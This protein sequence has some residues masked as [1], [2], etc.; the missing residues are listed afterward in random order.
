LNPFD[1]FAV[2]HVTDKED[3]SENSAY[4]S[5]GSSW[6]ELSNA[7]LCSI[8]TSLDISPVLTNS[9]PIT[10]TV[11]YPEFDDSF[12][13]FPNPSEGNI[14]VICKRDQTESIRIRV[15]NM[16]GKLVSDKSYSDVEKTFTVDLYSLHNGLFI[17]H[18]I[19]EYSVETKK[20]LIIK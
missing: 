20:V 19:S 16:N 9:E 14:N 18:F 2:N 3:P 8:S 15:F 17:V 11:S 7:S 5:D 10:D 13:I 4:T 1:S 12:Y 6:F